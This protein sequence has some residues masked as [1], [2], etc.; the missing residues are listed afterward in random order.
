MHTTVLHYTLNPLLSSFVSLIFPPLK[1]L[2]CLFVRTCVHSC[3]SFTYTG[4]LPKGKQKIAPQPVPTKALEIDPA[5]VSP[6][7]DLAVISLTAVCYQSIGMFRSAVTYFSK[8]LLVD[9]TSC[10]WYQR[11]IALYIWSRLDRNLGLFNLDD[12]VDPRIKDGWCKR[13]SWRHILPSSGSTTSSSPTNER[14]TPQLH[15][16]SIRSIEDYPTVPSPCPTTCPSSSSSSSSS[17]AT[18]T[19]TPENTS[20]PNTVH[21]TNNNNNSNSNN[22][23]GNNTK[24]EDNCKL[25]PLFLSPTDPAVT[26]LL[27]FTA[28]YGAWMQLRCVGFLP[29]TRQVSDILFPS[30]L[31]FSSLYFFSSLFFSFLLFLSFSLHAP[32]SV[33]S[34]PYF[35][36]ST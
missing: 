25:A 28:P 36:D 18:R 9:Q 29:N 30:L 4:R 13:A 2:I 22:N 3:I 8:A 27:S 7:G 6:S 34:V 24:M 21:T 1:S 19:V 33:V 23:N 32:P 16:K 26:Q 10:C 12:D 14:Y 35:T 5:S 11:E 31:F 20:S 17:A 15:P